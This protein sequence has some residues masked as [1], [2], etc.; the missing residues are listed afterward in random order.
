MVCAFLRSYLLSL[1]MVCVAIWTFWTL[2]VYFY[3]P[4]KRIK[5]QVLKQTQS[6]FILTVPSLAIFLVC[7]L[8]TLTGNAW[9]SLEFVKVRNHSK[10]VQRTNH[11]VLER[12][13]I[14]LY[15]YKLC[16]PTCHQ[17]QRIR[18]TSLVSLLY[19]LPKGQRPSSLPDWIRACTVPL[20]LIFMS[21]DF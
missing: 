17:K 6:L 20:H 9:G 2:N 5:A 10:E 11:S 1:H 14:W 8:C 18:L 16:S 7:L 21:E 4:T 15:G 12:E 19:R 3:G 13:R